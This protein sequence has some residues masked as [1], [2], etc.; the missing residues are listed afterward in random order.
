MM[1]L[2]HNPRGIFYATDRTTGTDQDIRKAYTEY[3][4]SG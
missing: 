1:N 2:D 4:V 3:A